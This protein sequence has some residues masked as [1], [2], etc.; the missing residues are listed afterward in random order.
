MKLIFLFSTLLLLFSCKKVEFNKISN[1]AY[2]PK[3]SLPLAYGSFTI[4]D[5]LKQADSV[6]KYLQ[7]KPSLQLVVKESIK[8]FSFDQAL[9]IPPLNAIPSTTVIDFSKPGSA[10]TEINN[11]APLVQGNRADAIPVINSTNNITP[12]DKPIT[13]TILLTNPSNPG[14]IDTTTIDE[15]NISDGEIKI[16]I[17]TDI[18][19]KIEIVYEITEMTQGGKPLSGTIVCDKSNSSISVPSLISLKDV[20]ANLKSK[21][22]T[23]II[24]NIFITFNSYKLTQTDKINVSVS[25][26]NIKFESIYGYFGK[27]NGPPI[28]DTLKIDQL[29]DLKEKGEFG[30][31]NPSL[32][33]Y[34]KNGFGIPMNIDINKFQ[35]KQDGNPINIVM[36]K[37]FDI[38]QPENVN[39]KPVLDSIVLNSN[40]ATNFDKLLSSK[41]EEIIFGAALKINKYGEDLIKRNFI[42]SKSTISL[43]AEVRVPLTGYAKNFTFEDTSD[44]SLPF[45]LLKSLNLIVLY[46]NSLPVDISGSIRFLDK[47]GKLIRDNQ[48]NIIDLLASSSNKIFE[49]PIM[50]KIDNNGGYYLDEN[51]VK[52]MEQK[53]VVIGIT[54]AQVPFLLNASKVIFKGSFNTFGNSANKPVSLYDYYGL[55]IKLAGDA[56]GN[57]PLKK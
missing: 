18:K 37:T 17:L 7:S 38:E 32:K 13:E 53:R 48:N 42:S 22:F 34:I 31:T 12:L 51:E 10:L 8:G 25:M 27:F 26:N 11:Y 56:Q 2:S 30:L 41:N 24:K 47:Q 33:L 36:S 14:F 57:L 16:D 1:S 9:T 45:D 55:S 6:D 29:S 23:F 46:K 3:L 28:I 21:K 52:N 4:S 40:T 39:S 44:V 19:H 5:I 35:I 54:S 20:K 43:D 49:S 50:T 15:I